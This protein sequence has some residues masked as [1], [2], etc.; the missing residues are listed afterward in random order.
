MIET[1]K[2]LE[3]AY[4]VNDSMTVPFEP[5]NREYK[6]VQRWLAEGNEPLPADPAE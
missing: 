1:V 5:E 6:M 2:L 4:F 3:N